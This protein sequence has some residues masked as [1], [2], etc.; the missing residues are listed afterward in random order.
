M[1]EAGHPNLTMV[2][3]AAAGL[4][5][6]ANWELETDFHGA[7]RAPRDVFEMNQ[8]F[9]NIMENWDSYRSK[10]LNTAKELDWYNRTTELVEI[11]KEFL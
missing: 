11:Y 5:L 7:W 1:L 4:P 6:I 8:G 9:H 2:E 10:A 3:A